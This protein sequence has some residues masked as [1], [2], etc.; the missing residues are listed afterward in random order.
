MCKLGKL[1]RARRQLLRS[2]VGNF[3]YRM[4]L[5]C[6]R[7]QSSEGMGKDVQ[8]DGVDCSDCVVETKEKT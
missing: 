3:G 6:K 5:G 8:Q 1:G 7:T 4:R 2:S